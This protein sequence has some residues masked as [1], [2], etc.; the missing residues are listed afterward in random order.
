[1]SDS[2][3][4]DEK[5]YKMSD[6][7]VLSMKDLLSSFT[8][9]GT[10]RVTDLHMKCGKPPCFRVDGNMKVTNGLPIDEETMDKLVAAVLDEKELD[11]FR[12]QR[13]VNC[14]RLIVGL[15]FRFNIFHD[16]R[17]PA[18]AIRAL[19]TSTPTIEFVGFPNGVW[20]DIIKLRP[21]L[22]LVT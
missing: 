5:L 15:R 14:A 1:M 22:V 16:S 17:G 7:R 13:S 3:P 8:R 19:D 11:T 6:N 2:S 4:L 10:A 12:K 9:Q 18:V 21:G 20:E